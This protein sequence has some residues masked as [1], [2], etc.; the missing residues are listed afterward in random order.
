MR[1]RIL[2]QVASSA[3]IAAALSSQALAQTPQTRVEGVIQR[4]HG[5]ARCVRPVADCG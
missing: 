3:V 1:I 2:R 4:L 5:A